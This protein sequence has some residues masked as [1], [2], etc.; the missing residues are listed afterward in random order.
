MVAEFDINLMKLRKLSITAGIFAFDI[1]IE[2]N[3]LHEQ[4]KAVSEIMEITGLSRAS[5][6]SYLPY[7]KEIY[8]AVR[9]KCECGEM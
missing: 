6:Y 9:V 7:S 5:I 4:G 2:V 1:C 8:N 3:E